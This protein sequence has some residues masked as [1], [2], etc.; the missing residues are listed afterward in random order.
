M[1]Q[2]TAANKKIKVES[3]AQSPEIKAAKKPAL[4]ASVYNLIGEKGKEISLPET[5]VT[6]KANPRLIAQAIRVYRANLRQGTQSTKT[7]GD[8]SGSTRKIYRQK[9]TGR[10]RHGSQKAP[11]FVGG[12]ISLGPKPRDFD[13]QLPVK[14][15]RRVIFAMMSQL[16]KDGALSVVEGLADTTGKTK[17]M[18]ALFRKIGVSKKRLLFIIEPNMKKAA[19]GA[20]NLPYLKITT[21]SSVSSIDLMRNENVIFAKEALE[22]LMGKVYPSYAGLSR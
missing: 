18:D 8:V 22:K 7:R 14:M 11:I 20:R 5:L 17:E 10:A 3:K 2:K 4:T 6:A 9:G 15:R 19:R 13:L 12:G 16:A 1:A 21:S